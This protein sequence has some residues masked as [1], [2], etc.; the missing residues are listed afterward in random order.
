MLWCFLKD[1]LHK[2]NITV[3]FYLVPDF[4]SKA[5]ISDI[6]YLNFTIEFNT[7]TLNV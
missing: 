3:F 2:I 5:G 4:L 7:V 6:T 1:R